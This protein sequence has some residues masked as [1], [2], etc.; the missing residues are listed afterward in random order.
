M[1]TYSQGCSVAFEGNPFSQVTN[2]TVNKGRAILRSGSSVGGSVT[3]ETLG[4]DIGDGSYGT[5]SVSG[6]GISLTARAVCT[7][8]SAIAAT[9]DVT[10]YSV[11]FELLD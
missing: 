8:T 2:V 7:G 10:R 9:N 5:L 1:A 11:T 6:G 4:G 3:I